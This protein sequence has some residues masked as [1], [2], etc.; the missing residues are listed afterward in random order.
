MHYFE[1]YIFCSRVP[2]MVHI[3]NLESHKKKHEN[4]ETPIRIMRKLYFYEE[5]KIHLGK[6]K[7]FYHKNEFN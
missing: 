5:K 1:K 2:H 4:T 6:K 3:A 7:F